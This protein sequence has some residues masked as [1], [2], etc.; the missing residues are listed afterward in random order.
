M[1]FGTLLERLFYSASVETSYH[2][3]QPFSLCG[4]AVAAVA[5][6]ALCQEA[7]CLSISHLGIGVSSATLTG[8]FV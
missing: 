6:V 5:T 7:F 4:C 3:S 8:I 2:L 1:A